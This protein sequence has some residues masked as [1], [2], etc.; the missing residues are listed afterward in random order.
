MTR[1]KPDEASRPFVLWTTV[2]PIPSPDAD[3]LVKVI[4]L[5]ALNDLLDMI[6][7]DIDQRREREERERMNA[8]KVFGWVCDD[9][10]N[11]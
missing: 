4:G 11:A 7:L 5:A 3:E 9:G 8:V 6:V 10:E 1:P 2:V